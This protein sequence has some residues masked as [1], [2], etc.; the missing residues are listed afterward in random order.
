M[1]RIMIVLT[2]NS[3]LFLGFVQIK[4][5]ILGFL[6]CLLATISNF[7]I[8]ILYL[9]YE[10]KLNRFE[11]RIRYKLPPNYNKK[12]STKAVV[13]RDGYIPVIGI[14]M[15]MWLM[16][17]WYSYSHFDSARQQFL[18]LLGTV[19]NSIRPIIASI[20]SILKI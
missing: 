7:G 4:D 1:P 19:G 3:I 5:S 2:T 17:L 10:R 12:P 9:L 20:L 13:G 16:S 11:D 18:D 14:F 8:A 15:L 6:L